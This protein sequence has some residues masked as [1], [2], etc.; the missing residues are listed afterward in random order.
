MIEFVPR[1][2]WTKVLRGAWCPRRSKIFVREMSLAGAAPCDYQNVRLRVFHETWTV[3][4]W[5][6]VVVVDTRVSR[7]RPKVGEDA[8][9]EHRCGEGNEAKSLVTGIDW[10]SDRN[11]TL[12]GDERAQIGARC[13]MTR[14]ERSNHG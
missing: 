9:S 2:R 1:R 14:E 8:N 3:R 4:L 6:K 10:P 12:C 11:E 13:V 7:R 5:S